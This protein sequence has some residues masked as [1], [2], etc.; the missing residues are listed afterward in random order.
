MQTATVVTV[1][2]A[3]TT[4]LGIAGTFRNV[5]HHAEVLRPLIDALLPYGT[6]WGFKEWKQGHNVH[7]FVTHD[8]R[9]FTLRGFTCDG[10]YCGLRLALRL[11]RSSEVRLWDV[12]SLKEIPQLAIML[13]KLAQEI[14][15]DDTPLLIDNKH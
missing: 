13:G 10:E 11:S 14:R 7:E 12:V 15:G 5:T 1:L 3:Q 2:R 8:N 6:E 9:R 4:G